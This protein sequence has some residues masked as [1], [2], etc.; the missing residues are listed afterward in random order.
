MEL[1]WYRGAKSRQAENR[2]ARKRL[3]NTGMMHTPRD[4]LDRHS[5][6][7]AAVGEEVGV[8]A[9]VVVEGEDVRNNNTMMMEAKP[10]RTQPNLRLVV[11]EEDV[12]EDGVVIRGVVAD[13]VTERE[14]EAAVVQNRT[15]RKV[16]K[17]RV[18]LDATKPSI[19]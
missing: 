17:T 2:A 7:E 12:V 9:A 19:T 3:R 18:M 6:E 14:G 15:P 13:R 11:A 5:V 16:P 4:R 10:R 8:A 1:S